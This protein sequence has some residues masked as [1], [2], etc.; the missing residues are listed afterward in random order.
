M[1]RNASAERRPVISPFLKGHMV[2][3]C[4]SNLYM[5]YLQEGLVQHI[6]RVHKP[7]TKG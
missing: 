4:A 5:W 6:R 2:I 1:S 7:S 3:L